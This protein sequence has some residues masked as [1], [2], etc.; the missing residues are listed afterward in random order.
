MYIGKQKILGEKKK[1]DWIQ[2]TLEPDPLDEMD[3]DEVILYNKEVLETLKT[4][5]PNEDLTG[6]R[7]LRC[8]APIAE[9][10]Q[11][12]LKY[13]VNLSF[14]DQDPSDLNHIFQSAANTLTRAKLKKERE[15]YGNNEFKRTVHQFKDELL[16]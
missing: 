2:V 5:A 11:V 1:D 12:L 16:S 6:L 9:I 3:G 10:L 4:E 8:V 7:N 14:S 13:N 15:F